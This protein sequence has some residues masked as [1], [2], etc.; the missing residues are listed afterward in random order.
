MFA[1]LAMLSFAVQ[2]VSAASDE[3]DWPALR[4]R[5]PYS[6]YGLKDELLK[7]DLYYVGEPAEAGFL[8]V[9]PYGTRLIKWKNSVEL[10][11]LSFTIAEIAIAKGT[12]IVSGKT[13]GTLIDAT[14]NGGSL[15]VGLYLVVVRGAKMNNYARKEIINGR[16]TYVT[17]ASTG[18]YFFRFLPTLVAINARSNLIEMEPKADIIQIGGLNPN[19]ADPDPSEDEPPSE[20][21]PNSKPNDNQDPSTDIGEEDDPYNTMPDTGLVWWPVPVFICLGAVL[22]TIGFVIRKK[23][24][25]VLK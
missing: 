10:E 7:V 9:A 13:G 16:L 19:P 6:S 1:M 17:Y 25:Q 24:S 18:R 21:D 14:D 11:N 15:P 5:S 2:T 12:P 4:V 22:L 23:A 20:G 3:H 8:P